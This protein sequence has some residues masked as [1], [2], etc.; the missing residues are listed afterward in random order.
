MEKVK[1]KVMKENGRPKMIPR[2]MAI[3]GLDTSVE[4]D[5]KAYRSL[6]SGAL[7]EVPVETAAYLI[8]NQ[9]CEYAQEEE[10]LLFQG[11][12]EEKD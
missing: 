6:Q 7:T 9:F 3:V 11:E 8:Q 4:A 5:V 10:S 1:I 2:M 12:K